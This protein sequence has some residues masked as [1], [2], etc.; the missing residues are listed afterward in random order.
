[1]IDISHQLSAVQRQVGTRVL[2]AGEVR[3]V[4][5]V[6]TY[7][8]SV[9]DVWEAC[10]SAERLPR[11]FLPVTGDLHVGGRYQLI[12]NAGGTVERCDPPHSFAATWEHGGN[13]SWIELQLTAEG[14]GR[15]RWQLDHLFPLDDAKW[16]EFG[17]G[18]VG[19]GWD[20]ALPGLATHLVT[21]EPVDRDAGMAWVASGEGRRFMA[22]SSR[23]WRDAN[24]V[25]GADAAVADATEQRTT[26]AYAGM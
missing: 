5:I 22:L 24:V 26:A 2:E 10:T 13:L 3:V 21:G 15:T 16:E 12:G 1:V 14:D 17:P 7:D 23:A 4:T 6:Q 20:L 8:A 19:V 25:A 11:W 18:A 9:E